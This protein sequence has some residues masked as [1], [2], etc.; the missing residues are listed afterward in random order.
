MGCV[1]RHNVT[2]S[3]GTVQQRGYIAT[4]QPEQP[5]QQ[6]GKRK[7]TLGITVQFLLINLRKYES[8]DATSQGSAESGGVL[9]CAHQG[10]TETKIC[11]SPSLNRGFTH[12]KLALLAV[13]V[14]HCGDQHRWPRSWNR[15]Y[16]VVMRV[17]HPVL[18]S[19][20]NLV[21]F[22]PIVLSAH[23]DSGG[24]SLCLSVSNLSSV[25]LELCVKF[26]E[27]YTI[28]LQPFLRIQPGLL[29]VSPEI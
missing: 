24:K 22:V 14:C 27:M 13:F 5:C 12:V 3:V 20:A 11:V 10:L 15:I 18:S 23:A 7:D 17:L 19:I 16:L 6:L 2:R 4:R 21:A 29:K 28:L 25:G 9:C 8:I 26:T 1:R